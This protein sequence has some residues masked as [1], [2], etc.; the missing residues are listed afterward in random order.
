MHDVTL[1][2][3][4]IFQVSEHPHSFPLFV[5]C[6]AVRVRAPG[7]G[8]KTLFTWTGKL[9]DT[10]KINE[11]FIFKPRYWFKITLSVALTLFN[12]WEPY[13]LTQSDKDITPKRG[14]Q[15]PDQ[16]DKATKLG[17]H[18]DCCSQPGGCCSAADSLSKHNEHCRN[19]IL[20]WVHFVSVFRKFIFIYAVTRIK[21]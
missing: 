15:F 16:Q 1:T 3:Q 7:G 19:V 11:L 20:F 8:A 5:F 18:S 14:M 17:Y 12:Q 2:F 6:K 13:P 21:I 9:N 4:I 10:I